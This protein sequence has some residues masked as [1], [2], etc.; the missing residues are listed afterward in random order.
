MLLIDCVFAPCVLQGRREMIE[1]LNKE[2]RQCKL[3]QFILQTGAP[4]PET[5]ADLCLSSGIMEPQRDWT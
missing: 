1:E 5:L 3:Q 2:L 4:P